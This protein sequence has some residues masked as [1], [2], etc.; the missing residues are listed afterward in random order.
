MYL[1]F[2]WFE[3]LNIFYKF[4]VSFIKTLK[5][6]KITFILRKPSIYK[7]YVNFYINMKRKHLLGITM[8]VF[9]LVT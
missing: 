4:V 6:L 3:N 5:T 2:F 9:Y 7:S 8:F 1:Y